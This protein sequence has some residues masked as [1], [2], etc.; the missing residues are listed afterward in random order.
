M[1]NYTSEQHVYDINGVKV[2]GQPGQYPT[3]LIGSI[4]YRGHKIVQ[5]GM[6]GIFNEDAAKA[7]LDQEAELS[8]ETGNPFI[9]DVLGESVEAL[10]RYVEFVM[11][12]SKA[13][14][15]L[16]SISPAVRM[17]ALKE[18]GNDPEVRKRLIYNS[19][20]EHYSE[21]E[22]AAIKESGIKTAVILAFSNKALK[23]KARIKLLTGDGEKEGL[24]D[25]AKRA[26][27]E[28]FLVD[29]GVL[30]VPSASWTS[31]AINVV[32]QEFGY[33]GG[34]APSNAV[35]LWKKMRSKGT[36]FF[37]VAGAAVFTYPVTQGASFI[38]YGPMVNAPW[39]YRAVATTDAMMAYNNKLTGVKFGSPEHPLL[40]IF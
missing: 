26:G 21:E 17:G 36:P 30:D 2:G 23:P 9:L 28:Q 40:K 32:N 37:E 33:P 11:K 1:L 34:C 18:L 31:E 14:F 4:F 8:A 7:L 12:N 29:P 24:I 25:A 15:L 27:I 20:D 22:L 35:Y 5:D 38:L 10:T 3:V 6:K 13:P 16:D 39:V 19:I